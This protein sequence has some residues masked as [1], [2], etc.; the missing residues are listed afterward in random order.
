MME[1]TMPEPSWGLV[2]FAWLAGGA[3][4]FWACAAMVVGATADAQDEADRRKTAEDFAQE[5][6]R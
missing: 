2:F 4:G 5:S 3:V 1:L 6:Q